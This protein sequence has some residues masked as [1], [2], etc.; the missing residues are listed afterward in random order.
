M[1]TS[2]RAI[3]LESLGTEPVAPLSAAIRAHLHACS[4]CNA[5]VQASRRLTPCLRTAP[6]L[7][8]A[9]SEVLAAVRERISAYVRQL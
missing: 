3:L 8:V 4:F 9:A 1:I 5:R 6:K 7:P 2:C